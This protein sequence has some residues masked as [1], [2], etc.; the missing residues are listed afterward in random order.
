[1][2][3][4]NLPWQGGCRC[5]KL[6]FEISAPPL[7][8]MACHCTGCQKMS[9][10]AFSLSMAIPESGFRVTQGEAVTGGLHGP[11]IHHRHCEWCKSWVF[12]ELEPSMG[13]VNVRPS[14]LDD[15]KWFAP[16]IETY[17]SEALPWATTG[18]KH[19]FSAFPAME[20]YGP[21]VEAFAAQGP[22]PGRPRGGD[23]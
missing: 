22:R 1:M 2:E 6:R 9:A 8:T 18:A 4:W 10:S 12:T 7:L 5:G 21:L 15:A 23:A 11:Q 16:F 20:D 3:D 13:F 17:T 19:R 14:M